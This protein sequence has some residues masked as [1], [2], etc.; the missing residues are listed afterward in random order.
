M[1]GTL[2]SASAVCGILFLLIFSADEVKAGEGHTVLQRF[3]YRGITLDD[4]SL[5][6]QFD[7]VRDYY[8]RIPND[9]LLKGFRARANRPAP[10][11]DLGGLYLAHGIFGQ[12]L[13]GF[14]RM[15]AA[16][17]DPACREKAESLMQGW[18]ECIRSDGFPFPQG[19]Q[20]LM[21]YDYDKF[22]GG[23]VDMNRYCGKKDALTYLSQITDWAARNLAGV[24]EHINEKNANWFA[25][26]GEP[27]GAPS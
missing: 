7:E 4:G 5:R 20:G 26:N 24:E 27:A 2:T 14:A 15:Y 12:L 21:P 10:G 13:S 6:R 19:Y 17:G 3:D 8:L 23:L 22:V 1:N 16:T 9:D 18:A 25:L 11:A